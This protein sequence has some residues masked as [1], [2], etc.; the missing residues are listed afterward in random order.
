[1]PFGGVRLPLLSLLIYD[2]DRFPEKPL[3]A[4]ACCGVMMKVRFGANTVMRGV[5][6]ALY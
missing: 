2:I 3:Q 5:E 4:T 6:E 1:M